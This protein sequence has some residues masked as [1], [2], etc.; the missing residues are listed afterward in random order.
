MRYCACALSQCTC[1]TSKTTSAAVVCD[2]L[3][4]V[5]DEE[6]TFVM[7]EDEEVIAISSD[8]DDGVV[9]ISSE[10]GSPIKLFTPTKRYHS[11]LN[12]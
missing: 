8:S 2:W 12:A 3:T 11:Q 4:F 6:L 5:V 10:A 9:V 7:D 1:K